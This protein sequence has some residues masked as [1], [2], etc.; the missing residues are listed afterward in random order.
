MDIERLEQEYNE[1]LTKL[2][3]T[4]SGSEEYRRLV[5]DLTDLYVMIDK[6]HTYELKRLEYHR[7]LDAE[8]EK[9]DAETRRLEAKAAS[10]RKI[11]AIDLVK[12]GLASIASLTGIML[13]GALDKETVLPGKLLSMATKMFPKI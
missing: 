5:N 4:T 12:T 3:G 6:E 8:R 7:Q 9:E 11:R 10:D 2:S 13:V 1:V